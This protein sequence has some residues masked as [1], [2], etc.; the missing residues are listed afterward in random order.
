VGFVPDCIVLSLISC[1]F[2]GKL[3]MLPHP[4]GGGFCMQLCSACGE[5]QISHTE[6]GIEKRCSD[7]TELAS[8]A[9]LWKIKSRHTHIKRKKQFCPFHTGRKAVHKAT[10]P[11][12]AKSIKLLDTTHRKLH[13]KR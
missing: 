3:N 13:L 6:T 5:K 2:L 11:Q 10:E 7:K 8:Q 12:N 1:G 4:H 9:V